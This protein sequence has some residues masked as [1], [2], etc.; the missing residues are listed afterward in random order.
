MVGMLFQITARPYPTLSS[1]DELKSL[2]QALNKADIKLVL[3]LVFNHTY[4]EH[5]WTIK[6]KQ[7]DSEFQQYYYM[8][9]DMFI[10]N[11]YE[12]TLREIFPQV[13]RGNF[14]FE[15]SCQKWG[16]TT[17]NNFQWDVNYTNPLF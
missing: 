16:W 9:D 13:R 15:P 1:I 10:P 7:G 17:F 3:D 5:E 6:A 8:F 2:A 12:E 11:Q 4:N 14:T